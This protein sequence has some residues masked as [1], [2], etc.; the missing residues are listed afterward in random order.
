MNEW[1]EETGMDREETGLGVG[2]GIG[3]GVGFRWSRV[4]WSRVEWSGADA[5]G[6]QLH[7]HTYSVFLSFLCRR[8]A[9]IHVKQTVVGE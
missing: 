4:E 8:V 6:W 2:V 7:I 9:A 3:I 5:E 1:E